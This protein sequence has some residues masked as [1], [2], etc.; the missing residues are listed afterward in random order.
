MKKQY[1]LLAALL[2]LL[3]GLAFVSLEQW[4][5]E[6]QPVSAEQA[7]SERN[8]AIADVSLQRQINKVNEDAATTTINKLKADNTTLTSTNTTLCTQIKTAKLPQPLCK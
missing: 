5:T 3:A 1:I 2:I 6:P 7:I 4:N 8:T